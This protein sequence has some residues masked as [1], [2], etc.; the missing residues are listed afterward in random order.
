M[1]LIEAAMVLGVAAVVIAGAL[2]LYNQA[3]STEKTAE[4]I[5]E[6]HLI[7]TGVR[8][9]YGWQKFANLDNTTVVRTKMVPLKMVGGTDVLKN[10]FGGQITVSAIDV[11][12][13]VDAGFEVKFSEVPADSCVVLTTKNYGH[14]VGQIVVNETVFDFTAGTAPTG[15]TASQACGN[16]PSTCSWLFYN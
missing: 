16:A 3:H 2:L 8:R 15:S 6:M 1:S 12:S 7:E 9:F 4:A 11:N 5:D 14:Q 13:I 10:T